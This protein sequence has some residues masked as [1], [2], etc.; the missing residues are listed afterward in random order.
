MFQN[1]NTIFENNII[2]SK[3]RYLYYRYETFMYSLKKEIPILN[4]ITN[5]WFLIS[6]R[7]T[8]S[9]YLKKNI[10]VLTDINLRLGINNIWYHIRPPHGWKL[11][12]LQVQKRDTGYINPTLLILKKISIIF[13]RNSCQFK[14]TF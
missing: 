6:T 14:S 13:L 7:Y 11:D 1:G 9:T 8:S 12:T 5:T 10:P 4:K 2:V 3:K